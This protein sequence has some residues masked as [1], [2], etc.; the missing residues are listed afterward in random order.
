[1]VEKKRFYE[2]MAELAL[3]FPNS[4]IHIDAFEVYY[5]ILKEADT[6]RMERAVIRI[7]KEDDFFPNIKRLSE[8]CGLNDTQYNYL[9]VPDGFQGLGGKG[10]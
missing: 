10:A 4:K 9:Q 5:R 7:M 8:L 6:D 2:L 3:A 1:M